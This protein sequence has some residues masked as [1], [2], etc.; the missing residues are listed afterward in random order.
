MTIDV[1]TNDDDPENDDLTV[2][3]LSRPGNGL[4]TIETDNTITYTPNPN[5]HGA[6]AFSYTLSD[7]M[8]SD[9]G[10]VSV[11]IRSVNDPPEF[12]APT[13]SGNKPSCYPCNSASYGV[14]A[15][16]VTPRAR[17]YV[18]YMNYLL[19]IGSL[20]VSFRDSFSRP[21]PI[22]RAVGNRAVARASA[23]PC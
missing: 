1:L 11:T 8:F 15:H 2:S 22:T 3:L 5:Y 18:L 6:D 14:H 19:A 21:H 4:A 23:L 12:R 10:T 17:E 13:R 16:H 20:M 9:E 7:G